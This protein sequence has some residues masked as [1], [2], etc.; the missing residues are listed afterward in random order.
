MRVFLDNPWFASLPGDTADAVLAAA[1]PMR[2]A[3][4]EALFRQGEAYD[5]A[6]DSFFGVAKGAIKFCVVYPDGSEAILTIIE[7]GNWFGEA[8][9]LDPHVRTATT[10]AVEETELLV[11][12]AEHFNAMMQRNAFAQAVARLEASRL[13]A[14]FGI[15]ADIALRSTR[16][17]VARR[18]VLLARGDLTG[19]PSAR[20]TIGTSQDNIA[21]MLGVG[22]TTLNKELQALARMGAI[23]LRYGHIVIKD[24]ELLVATSESI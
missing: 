15:L 8:M 23:E 24:M 14:V 13:V 17:R 7:P 2:L 5:E 18:L 22:R 19:S 10:I 9:L 11:V 1:R 16:T 3:Q 21:M 12:S 20:P 4:G 6:R